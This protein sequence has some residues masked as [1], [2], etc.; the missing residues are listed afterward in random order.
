[1]T[2]ITYIETGEGWLYLSAVK[3]LH[4]DVIVGWSMGHRQTRELVLQALL[5]TLWQREDRPR[6]SCI[7]IAAVSSRAANTSGSSRAI[8]SSRA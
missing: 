6:S 4:T 1:M 7:P 5:M 8:I 3:D 2:D